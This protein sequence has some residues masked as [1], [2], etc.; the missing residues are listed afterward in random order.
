MCGTTIGQT[1]TEWLITTF[2]LT[3][4]LAHTHCTDAIT[5]HSTK[6]KTE[7][8][9]LTDTLRR[10]HHASS[11]SHTTCTYTCRTDISQTLHRRYMWSIIYTQ[12]IALGFSGCR[13]HTRI[14]WH[15]I[16]GAK[17]KREGLH[18]LFL[19]LA[20]AYGSDPHSLLWAGFEFFQVPETV[21]KLVK[22]YFQELQFCPT[23]SHFTTAWPPL[24][25]GNMAGYTIS[26]LAF[27]MAMVVI[28]RASRWA[29]GGKR[30]QEGQ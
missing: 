13:E 15:Q 12:L 1:A 14:I 3:C 20:N 8:F 24:D 10:S 23:A 29:G 19:D 30:L 26:P 21:T 17:K 16:Q 4:S 11:L 25:V 18:I 2:P 28:I 27:K 9:C 5:Q 22:H 6:T 7:G